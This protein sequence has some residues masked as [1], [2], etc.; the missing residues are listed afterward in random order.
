MAPQSCGAFLLNEF[1]KKLKS[2]ILMV[3]LQCSLTGAELPNNAV[4]SWEAISTAYCKCKI[5]CGKW[6][7]GRQRTAS[8]TIPRAG[9]TCAAP[10]RIP[11]GTWLY[12]ESVGW[13]RVED[14]LAKR[15]DSRVEVFMD[16][17]AQ[18]KR[19][20]IKRLTVARL[21]DSY[22]AQGKPRTDTLPRIKRAL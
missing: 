13:R 4:N 22:L 6:A 15:F 19:F 2:I 9:I 20:G 16:S 3:L 7:N 5:C 10:R 8:G 21:R 11:F 18:A 14:R 1:M 17:H 12:I